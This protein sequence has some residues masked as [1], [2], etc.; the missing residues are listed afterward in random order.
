MSE[1]SFWESSFLWIAFRNLIF[2]YHYLLQKIKSFN[3]TFEFLKIKKNMLYHVIMLYHLQR[4]II[5]FFYNR[6]TWKIQYLKE[7]EGQNFIPVFLDIFVK[8]IEIE[9]SEKFYDVLNIFLKTM[10]LRSLERLSLSDAI[11]ENV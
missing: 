3:L 9:S 11:L 4:R 5:S 10:K 6:K 2:A 7:E 8:F 1:I